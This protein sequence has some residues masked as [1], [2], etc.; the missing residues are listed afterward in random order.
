MIVFSQNER[1]SK[2]KAKKAPKL[3]T[4]VEIKIMGLEH[5]Q[6]PPMSQG[7]NQNYCWAASLSWWLKAVRNKTYSVGDL[8]YIYENWVNDE[9]GENYGALNEVGMSKLL[10]DQRWFLHYDKKK[11][12]K[13]KFEY[14]DKILKRGP[15]MVAYYEPKVKGYHM[16]VIVAG[17]GLG[18]VASGLVVMD[19]NYESFQIRTLSYY[20][21]Y[22]SDIYFI[23]KAYASPTP[24]YAYEQSY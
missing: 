10:N 12:D 19:P 20:K 16:N 1:I 24:T 23:Y 17:A 9:E 4:R 3:F 6:Y 8:L 2:C 14:L 15:V 18:D 7:E 21:A 11:N 22:Y 5:I 13:I